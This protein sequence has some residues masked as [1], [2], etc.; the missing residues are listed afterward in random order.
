MAGSWYLVVSI[1]R[2]LV[3]Q[4]HGSCLIAKTGV[5]PKLGPA[6][7][8]VRKMDRNMFEVAISISEHGFSQLAFCMTSVGSFLTC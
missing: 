4:G 1:V 2:L 7:G 8:G 6:S 5:H 3:V